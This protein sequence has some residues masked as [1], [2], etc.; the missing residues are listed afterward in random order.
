MSSPPR[1]RFAPSPTGRLHLGNIRTALFN[2]LFA[3]GG[4][5]QFILRIE[6]TDAQRSME[7]AIDAILEDLSWLGLVWDEGPDRDG[8][9][10]PYRQSERSAVYQ[11]L[12]DRLRET[13]KVYP[14][15]RTADELKAYRRECINAGRPPVYDREWASLT[16]TE[17]RRREDKGAEPALRFQIPDG[18]ALDFEDLVRGPQAFGLADI[19]DFVVLR[20]DGTPPFFFCNAVDDALMGV[21]HVLRGED[22]LSNTPRQILLLQALGMD[23][24]RYGH[25]PL[26]VGDDGTPL[27]KRTGAASLADLR[28]EGLLPA[29][30]ANLAARLGHAC[31]RGDLMDMDTLAAQFALERIGKAPARF[32]RIQLEHWQSLAIQATGDEDLAGWAGGAALDPVPEATR[33]AFMHWVRP[34]VHR[35]GDVARWA[36][37]LYGA[38]P[39]FD[40]ATA[41]ELERAGGRFFRVALSVVRAGNADLAA[42]R[43]AVG[44]ELGV[45]GKRLFRPLRL[46]LTGSG[47]GPELGP[48]F[49]LL[50]ADTIGSRLERWAGPKSEDEE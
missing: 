21:T 40:E 50:P 48:L 1:T 4:G 17:I 46:A 8:D 13:G 19:G 44:A 20:S 39:R 25:L 11:G 29:A 36:D 9:A 26:L 37:V 35:P 43:S 32:D 38:G 34:N 18:R 7:G 23:A 41:A 45:K 2:Y 47:E 42:I 16:D 10:G 30:I 28:E 49:E 22:H 5:G 14:C 24:P 15:W 33:A 27:S 6:D 12:L 31:D 3:R